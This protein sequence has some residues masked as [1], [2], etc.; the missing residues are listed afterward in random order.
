M[1]NLNYLAL[2]IAAGLLIPYAIAF[3][4]SKKEDNITFRHTYDDNDKEENE[5]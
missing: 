1:K 3:I 4:K 5:Y 2:G